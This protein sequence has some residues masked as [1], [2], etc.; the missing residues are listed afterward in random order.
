VIDAASANGFS[1]K[2]AIGGYDYANVQW[3]SE[4]VMVARKTADLEFLQTTKMVVWDVP[5][6]TGMHAWT[7]KGNHDLEPLRKPPRK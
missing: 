1:W 5:N 6:A 7:D 4:W 3:G 2:H